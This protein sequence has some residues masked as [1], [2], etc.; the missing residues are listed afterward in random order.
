[1]GFANVK[2]AV[3]S[4][5]P[6]LVA[7]A[8]SDVKNISELA[9]GA[10]A[11]FLDAHQEEVA[12]KLFRQIA[13]NN[14]ECNPPCGC[15]LGNSPACRPD[16]TVFS[17]DTDM[18]L[19]KNA[20]CGKVLII[21]SDIED[22]Y[23]RMLDDLPVDAILLA[24]CE[25]QPCR[26]T[27][28]HYMLC[29]RIAMSVSKPLIVHVGTNI[30]VQEITDLWDYGIDGIMV[31]VDNVDPMIISNLEKI[32]GNLELKAKRKKIR[33]APIIPNI[34]VSQSQQQPEPA[35]DEDDDEDWDMERNHNL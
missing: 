27:L 14:C 31:D 19:V 2:A 29:Q 1:M 11:V 33:L 21:S 9:K 16:F 10:D 18:A 26:P 23:L 35:P 28:Q 24:Q 3:F 34:A 13:D 8:C 5:K 22:K 4:V 6:V 15:W 7:R 32:I 20:S 17:I 25:G 12:D 30:G